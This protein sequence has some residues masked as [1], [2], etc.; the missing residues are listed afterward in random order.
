VNSNWR[1][2]WRNLWRNR[3]R[4]WLTVG[5]MVFSNILLVFLISLQLGSYDMMIEAT[6]RAFTGHLQVQ[7]RGYHE[8]PKIRRSIPGVLDRAQAL[9]GE[10]GL[11]ALTARA[12]AFALASSDERSLGIQ[13][14][15]IE[16]DYEP[17]VSSL[18]GLVREGRWFSGVDAE[19]II[20]GKVL[21]RNLK[22][23]LG[24]EVTFIGSGR[25]GSFAAGIA[26]VVGILDSGMTELDRSL[27][28]MP[29]GYFDSVFTMEGHGHSIVVE[30]ASLDQVPGYQQRIEQ[31][32]SA[33]TDLVVLD[34]DALQ[35]GLRQ[36]IRADMT[37][38]WFVYSILIVL[39]AFS[40]LNTQ[41]MS[42]L[43]RTREFGIM[44]ALGIKPLR[45]GSL[46]AQ[47]TALMSLMGL[48]IGVGIG[49]MLAYYLSVVGFTYPG[50]EE[51]GEKF[52]L[53]AYVYPEVS[54]LSMLWGPSMVF[55]G[56]ML[57]AIYPALRLLHLQPV[58]AMRAV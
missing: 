26:R 30:L 58:A 41:L 14:V 19:E 51:M 31:Y 24:D 44:L 50:M 46:V 39:V 2:A 35:P 36:A 6:L 29:I 8:Q 3:R 18:P 38:A 49:W 23:S 45:L 43:E 17:L 32:L 20:L 13:I 16:P 1:L 5:A 52:N 9:R 48:S 55:L 10:L 34:W 21:A 15:G 11:E 22:L 25:D 40:V 54:L 27:A 56:A 7:H 42:V 28:Q 37:S 33:E 4:T 57:A 53:P 12:S 47:E